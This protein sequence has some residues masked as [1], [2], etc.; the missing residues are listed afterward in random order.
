MTAPGDQVAIQVL[1]AK[2]S[3]LARLE[4]FLLTASKMAA[5]ED[6]RV[7]SVKIDGAQYYRVAYGLYANL[8]AARAAMR[9]LPPLLAA[10]KPYYRSVERM[11]SQNR[12]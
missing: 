5:R 10:Q 6:F 12:Q 11:R 4:G 9:E 2:D 7:Y 8:E 1:T 3:E